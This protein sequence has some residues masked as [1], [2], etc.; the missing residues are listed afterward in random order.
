MHIK[1]RTPR[2]LSVQAVEL[3]DTAAGLGSV[4]ALNGLGYIHFYGE[5]LPKNE[6]KAFHYFL[7][8]SEEGLDGDSF[9]NAAHCLAHGIGAPAA[10]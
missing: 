1:V 9:T 4:K 2:S 3:Y 5:S 10:V 8:A 6:T 7:R